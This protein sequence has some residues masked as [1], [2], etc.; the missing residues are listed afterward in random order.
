MSR[1][2]VPSD[3][4]VEVEEWKEGRK[5]EDEGE[6]KNQAIHRNKGKVGSEFKINQTMQSSRLLSL[7]GNDRYRHL[8]EDYN[9]FANGFD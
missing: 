5:D 6:E 2:R 8:M 7:A 9:K 4:Q 1:S 3:I